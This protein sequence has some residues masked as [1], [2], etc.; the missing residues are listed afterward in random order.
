M[1]GE[2]GRMS[3]HDYKLELVEQNWIFLYILHKTY[4]KLILINNIT[5]L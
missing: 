4:L 5:R 3:G 2:E 1:L